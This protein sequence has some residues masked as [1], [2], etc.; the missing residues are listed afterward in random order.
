MSTDAGVRAGRY[1][2][3]TGGASVDS[4]A[5]GETATAAERTAAAFAAA[6]FP[7]MPARTLLALVS[8][9]HASLTAA[10]LAERLGA[11]AAAVSGAVRYL[12]TVGFVHRVS[13]PGSRRDLYALHEDEWYV[14][15]M[16]NNPAYEKLAALTDATAETLPEGSPAR[17]RVAEMARFYRFLNSRLPALLNE[18]ER[19]R[20]AQP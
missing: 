20:E 13:Q 3:A 1:A 12:Q 11:S 18:W 6:G 4:G 9:E 7:K 2:Q 5:A 8:S 10:E 17:T 14:V 15:S 16:R 19:E